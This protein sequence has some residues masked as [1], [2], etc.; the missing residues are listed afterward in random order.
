MTADRSQK[1]FVPQEALI[2]QFSYHPPSTPAIGALHGEVRDHSF[3][4]AN[5]LNENLPECPEKTLAIRKVREAM[6]WGNA[7]IACHSNIPE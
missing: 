6:M 2:S 7:A 1:R 5:W 3:A 4:L